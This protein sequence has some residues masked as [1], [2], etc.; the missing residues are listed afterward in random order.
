[1]IFLSR[2][3]I[4]AFFN[5]HI[6]FAQRRGPL[7]FDAKKFQDEIL[8]NLAKKMNQITCETAYVDTPPLFY[9]TSGFGIKGG[10]SLRQPFENFRSG[11]EDETLK[12]SQVRNRRKYYLPHGSIVK[13]EKKYQN[14]IKENRELPKENSIMVEKPFREGELIYLPVIVE[15]LPSFHKDEE[16]KKSRYNV[17]RG[18]L[19]NKTEKD[20]A[21]IKE[22]GHF[23]NHSL[24]RLDQFSFIVT[25]DTEF[26]NLP[27]N[28]KNKVI[29]LVTNDFGYKVEMCCERGQKNC[30]HQYLFEIVDEEKEFPVDLECCG[31]KILNSLLPIPMRK[32]NSFVE[33][34]KA[35]PSHI[36]SEKIVYLD[37]YIPYE[38]ENPK[39]KIRKVAG[40]TNSLVQLP[41]GEKL[42][43]KQDP[44]SKIC[45][46]Y[47][48]PF[49]AV[50]YSKLCET[51]DLFLEPHTQCSFLKALKEFQDVCLNFVDNDKLKESSKYKAEKSSFELCRVQVGDMFT[52]DGAHKTHDSGRCV[53]IRPFRYDGE[54]G[55]QSTVGVKRLRKNYNR[56]VTELFVKTL[57]KYGASHIRFTDK[58]LFS[59]ENEKKYKKLYKNVG[60]HADHLHICFSDVN[61]GLIKPSEDQL[62]SVR[63]CQPIPDFESKLEN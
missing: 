31:G 48:M 3:L 30:K 20:R 13:V 27:G 26:L 63:D 56:D 22:K 62:K 9:V 33:I 8:I 15:S 23:P 12:Y 58:Y 4:L 50:H 10:D 34:L 55:P 24:K 38:I 44:Y 16:L 57:G 40:Y 42:D 1:M 18:N 17:L 39:T 43:L 52:P 2:F 29:R 25:K 5:S 61:F 37:N 35:L 51:D 6:T 11:E 47:E 59:G 54:I 7:E 45:A 49:N 28:L 21:P 46:Y 53:D 41:Y 19:K 36:D 14:Y 32:T 60:S